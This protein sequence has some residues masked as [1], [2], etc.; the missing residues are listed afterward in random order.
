MALRGKG[1]KNYGLTEFSYFGNG[2]DVT[3]KSGVGE[4]GGI[5]RVPAK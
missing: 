4:V 1:V 2:L 3:D 5:F